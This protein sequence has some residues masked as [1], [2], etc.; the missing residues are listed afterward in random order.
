M[1]IPITI[2]IV[3]KG[4]WYIART[5]E[6]DFVTQ[7]RTANE[8]KKNLFEVIEIQFEEM[9]KLST[10]KDYLKE[11][12]YEIDEKMKVYPK[13]ISLEKTEVPVQWR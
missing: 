10:L 7:G 9:D 2:E 11:C 12:G 13:L 4:I 6:L 8:A 1:I 3:K 5:V